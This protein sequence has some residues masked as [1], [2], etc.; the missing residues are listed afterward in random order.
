MS[1]GD[2]CLPVMT[3]TPGMGDVSPGAA[4]VLER[5]CRWCRHPIE[6]TQEKWCSKRC[7]QTA[8]RW[9]KLAVVEGLGDTPKRIA[10]ADPPF[11]G[12][13]RK[14]YGD[15]P[16]FAGEVD[17]R[18]LVEQLS[19][20]DGWALSTSQEALSDVLSLCPRGVEV[21]PW[22][23]THHH[24]PARG[25]ANIHEYVLVVPARRRKPGVPDALVC[26]VARG[27]DSDLIGRKPLKFISWLFQ[28]LGALPV[29]SLDDKFPG[30][31]I[32]GRCWDEFRRSA[33]SLTP[34]GVLGRRAA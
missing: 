8:W 27:G 17:H 20:F 14:Y 26:A 18:R 15:Q 25:I 4:G 16:T 7:R 31:G 2:A 10:Y 29:D 19:T 22:V 1:D 28:L 11:P 12:L 23:K 5:Q 9:R 3:S 24:P 21:C 32:V 6:A 34:A 33:P 13:S 30:S